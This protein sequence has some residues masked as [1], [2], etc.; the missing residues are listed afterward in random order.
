M[1][2]N[3]LTIDV[4]HEACESIRPIRDWRMRTLQLLHTEIDFIPNAEFRMK[5]EILSDAVDSILNERLTTS[6]SNTFLPAHLRTMCEYPLLTP[7]QEVALFREM[8]YVKFKANALR[9]GLDPDHIDR[10]LVLTI[11]RLLNRAR[12]IRD[13]LIRSNLRLAMSIVKRFVTP[14]QSFDELFS[15][16]IVILMKAV[17]KYDFDRGFRFSTYAYRSIAREVFRTVTEAQTKKEQLNPDVAELAVEQL[18][19]RSSMMSDQIWAN[20]RE[21]T[22]K[23]LEKLDRREQVIIRSRYAW[24]AHRKVQT[25]QHLAD[26]LGVSKERVRYIEQRAVAKLKKMAAEFEIDELFSAAMV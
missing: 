19:N 5:E 6:D 1:S 24:G 11:E 18:G 4:G 13:H 7:D 23:M 8:N 10:T 17:E 3:M 15:D 20:L 2:E 14:Q 25:F 21:L 26:K 12:L 22:S 16:G 9:A